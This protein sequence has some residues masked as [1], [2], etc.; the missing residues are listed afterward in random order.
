MYTLPVV[1]PP[2]THKSAVLHEALSDV[3]KLAEE[4]LVEADNVVVFGYSCPALDFESANL[5]TRAHR[6][7]RPG[8]SLSVIDPNGAVLTRYIDVL[9]P[10]RLSYY[11]SGHEYL[12]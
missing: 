7:R 11:A 8:S 4:R 3:W 5:L 10:S 9:A 1:V 12:A 6:K 2:V